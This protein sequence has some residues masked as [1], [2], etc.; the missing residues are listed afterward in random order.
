MFD[1]VTTPSRVHPFV[2][3]QPRIGLQDLLPN[4][5][6]VA[7]AK[8]DRL[9][10]L[11][12]AY[13][14]IVEETGSLY[15]MSPDRYPLVVFGDTNIDDGY[16]GV[17]RIDPP[18]GSMPFNPGDRDFPPDV[19]SVTRAMKQKKLKKLCHS[20][21][22]DKRCLTGVRPL[23]SSRLSRLLDGPAQVPYPPHMR[24]P[25]E[26]MV[27]EPRPNYSGVLPGTNNRSISPPGFVA[28]LLEPSSGG[29]LAH[30]GQALSTYAVGLVTLVALFFWIFQKMDRRPLRPGSRPSENV[31]EARGEQAPV[32][33]VT[34]PKE[35]VSSSDKSASPE[36]T[37]VEPPTPEADSTKLEMGAPQSSAKA[38]SFDDAVMVTKATGVDEDDNP[39]LNGDADDSDADQ[40][41]TQGRR[42]PARRK[43][44]RKK[45][46]AAANGN[47]ED[48]VEGNEPAQKPRT[49]E[50]PPTPKANGEPGTVHV[51]S[52]SSIVVPPPPTPVVVEPSL[53]VSET[54]LGKRL[55]SS[56]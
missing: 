19:D 38:V 27:V 9:P 43:R 28:R 16:R 37:L 22:K 36:T 3:L 1:V 18:P 2:L 29:D 23:E 11:E 12:S 25:R 32:P 5:D 35:E 4:F 20:G 30:S 26:G 10:N 47:V 48:V 34:I 55:V 41:P 14:G 21:S 8:Q 33:E 31:E 53:V 50:P 51:V 7:A 24:D 46:G 54:I 6:L 52:P 44:G 17:G 13:V 39:D 40:A 49:E 56:Y 15:A 45:K 42:K